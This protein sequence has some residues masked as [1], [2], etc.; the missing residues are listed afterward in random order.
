MDLAMEVQQN[1]LPQ[2][3]LQ[4][5]KLDIVGKSIYCDETGG[6]Y[7]DFFQFPALG[8]RRVGIAVGDVVGHG[9]SA[10]LLMTTVAGIFAQPD[11]TA[12]RSC[13]KGG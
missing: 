13:P 5:D 4:I 12:R 10:A 2:K 7:F 6:D 8:R 9:V 3:P 11:G 1:L